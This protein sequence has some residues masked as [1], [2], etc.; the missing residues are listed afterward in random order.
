VATCTVTHT[1]GTMEISVGD[2]GKITFEDNVDTVL[3]CTFDRLHGVIFDGSLPETE[4]R[5][6]KLTGPRGFCSMYGYLANENQMPKPYLFVDERLR[7]RSLALL[8]ELTL[9]HE[10]C[11]FKVPEH[12]AAFVKE[13]LRA[14]QRVSWEPLVGKC[15]PD[16]QVV[17]N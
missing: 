17:E 11:H 13:F 1:S 8:A 12:N 7:D 5:W 3:L 4:I 9:I 16:F 6:A 14:L 2:F 10:M 15:V